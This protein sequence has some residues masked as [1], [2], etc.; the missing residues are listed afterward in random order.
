MHKDIKI[1]VNRNELASE[2]GL[3]RHTVYRATRNG[4]VR[5]DGQTLTGY[6]LFRFTP[7]RLLAIRQQLLSTENITA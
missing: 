4:A 1:Y 6:P 5:P 2:L 3:P 7:T